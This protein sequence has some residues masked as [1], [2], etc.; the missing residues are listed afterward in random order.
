MNTYT[1]RD[2]VH[3]AD[4]LDFFHLI[5]GYRKS[6]RDI[7]ENHKDAFDIQQIIQDLLQVGFWVNQEQQKEHG[8]VD[9]TFN[10]PLIEM[11]LYLS[12]EGENLWKK[13]IAFW[14]TQINK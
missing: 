14:R 1:L 12:C 7:Y 11:S 13:V 4:V 2:A 5:K 9:M 6:L 10:K 3:L 8:F